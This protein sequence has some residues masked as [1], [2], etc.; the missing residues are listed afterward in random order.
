ML[1]ENK[2][3]DRQLNINAPEFVINCDQ[4]DNNSDQMAAYISND[5]I[6]HISAPN[7]SHIINNS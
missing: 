3:G 5:S 1:T 6:T 4:P 7:I 2:K